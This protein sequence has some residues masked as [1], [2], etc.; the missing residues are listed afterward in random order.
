MANE[1]TLN[2]TSGLEFTADPVRIDAN[3]Q[4]YKLMPVDKGPD[5]I[6]VG[7]PFVVDATGKGAEV[8]VA[9]NQLHVREILLRVSLDN[10][11]SGNPTQGIFETGGAVFNTNLPVAAFTGLKGSGLRVGLP[12]NNNFF[13]EADLA[14]GDLSLPGQYLILKIETAGAT[15][16]RNGLIKFGAATGA[17]NPL[18]VNALAASEKFFGVVERLE[19]GQILWF[20][21]SNVGAGNLT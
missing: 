8:P 16:P 2:T 21:F 1:S 9:G 4:A 10:T 14:S 7:I 13:D 12:F 3:R 17:A 5:N 11:T 18:G 15:I 6:P 19:G 20:N